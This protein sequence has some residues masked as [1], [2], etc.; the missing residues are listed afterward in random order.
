MYC[1]LH[2]IFFTQSIW[3]INLEGRINIQVHRHSPQLKKKLADNLEVRH[4]KGTGQLLFAGQTCPNKDDIMTTRTAKERLFVVAVDYV[5][6]EP[7][8]S[9]KSS[10]CRLFKT[11][12]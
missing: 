12:S 6:Y 4:R 7:Y 2:F 1:E 3:D 9:Y 8:R 11:G 10:H 5:L